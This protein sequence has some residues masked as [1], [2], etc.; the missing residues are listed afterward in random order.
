MKGLLIKDFMLIKNQRQFFL[1][2]VLISVLFAFIYDNPS[3]PIS[4]MTILCGMFT[5]S[6]IGYD[7]FENGESFLFCLPVTRKEYVTGKYI[8][9]L[10]MTAFSFFCSSLIGYAAVVMRHL[11]YTWTDYAATAV[12]SWLL[13][14]LLLAFILP[15]QLKFQADKGRIVQFIIIGAG[16]VFIF[17]IVKL[18]GIDIIVT[19]EYMLS[20]HLPQLAA[21]TVLT[22]ITAVILSYM[23]SLK[24]MKDK[25]F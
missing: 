4:Y 14:A 17:L 3:F 19:L 13:A 22:V 2:I 20:N 21:G 10:V 8:L 11:E 23:V 25:E 15:V 1:T 7:T 6:T 5:V 9:G 16:M 12:S 24:I 18:S